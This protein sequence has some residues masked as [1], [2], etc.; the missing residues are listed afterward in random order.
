M[1]RLAR[2]GQCGLAY[3]VT[4][5]FHPGSDVANLSVFGYNPADCY[6][7]R[8]P[9]E[10][11]SMGVELGVDDVAF[12]LNLVTLTANY[13]KLYM[14]D[15]SADHI[16]TD[17]AHELISCLQEE[18][19]SSDFQFYPGVSYRH[20]MVWK[21]GK[22]KM[23]FFPPHDISDQAVDDYLPQGE[24]ADDLIDLMTSSQMLFR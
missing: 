4:D 10:A 7:G 15:F 5:G 20:L 12:R 22:D 11:A 16:T 3:T 23:K 2:E 24:G 14:E 19:G 6:S 17:E 9:L 13:G 18:L 8:S 1:D 21:N